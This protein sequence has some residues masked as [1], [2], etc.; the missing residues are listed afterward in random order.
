MGRKIS[1]DS[2][3]L[4]NKGLELIEAC[5]LFGLPPAQVE[6]VVHP[7]SIVHSLVEYI[8]GSMLAQLGNPDMRTPIAHALGWPERIGSG[9]ESL[10]ILRAARLDFEA[11][12]LERFPAPGAGAQ[13]GGSGRHGAGGAERRE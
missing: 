2:A 7:Q 1:V 3:T 13:R 6:V 8:D 4:M 12:D 10:D 5:L 9:V 11:P